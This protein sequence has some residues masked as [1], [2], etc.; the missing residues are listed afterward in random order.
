[1]SVLITDNYSLNILSSGIKGILQFHGEVLEYQ[2]VPS[3]P[4]VSAFATPSRCKQGVTFTGV[5]WPPYFFAISSCD[6]C[7]YSILMPFIYFAH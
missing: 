4:H 2:A 3:A 6:I 5:G 7:E 1:M